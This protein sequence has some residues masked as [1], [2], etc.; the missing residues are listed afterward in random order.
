MKKNLFFVIALVVFSCGKREVLL[1]Q[2]SESK[3]QTEV[4]D[5]SA[6][7]I[8]FDEVTQKAELNKNNL[9][10]TTNWIFNVDRRLTL[11]DV[12]PKIIDLQQ[13]RKKSS[14]H[15]N[16]NAQNFF[17]VADMSDKKLKFLEFT[18]IEF[19]QNFETKQ[20]SDEI[21]TAENLNS[22][23]K[24]IEN[25]KTNISEMIFL[26]KDILFQDFILFLQKIQEEK[27]VLQKINI[28]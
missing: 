27:I 6:I 8:F 10:S 1:P 12:V 13:K 17:S 15:N 11:G 18:K 19:L 20:L 2:V 25:R 9:I 24:N 7:Y 22:L 28:N 26:E 5:Y 4:N 3:L 16:P 23:S 21:L 14:F